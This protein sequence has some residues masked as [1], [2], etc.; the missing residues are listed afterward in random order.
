MYKKIKNYLKSFNFWTY[1]IFVL[2]LLG[3]FRN[4]AFL[5]VYHPLGQEVNSIFFALI[6]VYLAQILLMLMKRWEVWIISLL[7]VIFCIYVYPDFSFTPFIAILKYMV[8]EGLAS[9]GYG[10]A[11]FLNFAFISLGFSAEII[12]TYLLYIYFPR[13]KKQKESAT[14]E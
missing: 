11:H 3:L 8:F 9:K 5:R 13:T 12:K 10:W 1:F 2:C 14:L 4:A 6:V 7:Q